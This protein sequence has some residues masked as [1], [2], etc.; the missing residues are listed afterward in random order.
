MWFS[1]TWS[2][3]LEHP[4]AC[5]ME[6]MSDIG[7]ETQGGIVCEIQPYVHYPSHVSIGL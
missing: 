4:S 1:L 6:I 3:S 5:V 2:L 7:I